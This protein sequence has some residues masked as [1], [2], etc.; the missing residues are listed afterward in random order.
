MPLPAVLPPAPRLHHLPIKPASTVPVFSLPAAH[1]SVQLMIEPAR[2]LGFAFASADVLFEIDARGTLLFVGGALK[3]YACDTEGSLVGQGAAVFFAPAEAAKLVTLAGAL[4][5]GDR[6]GPLRLKLAGGG[7]GHVC[8]CRLPQNG[9]RISCTLARTGARPSLVS[10]CDAQ[11]G[12]AGRESFLAAL[13][14]CGSDDELALVNIPSLPRV[15]ETLGPEK[16]EK[17][18]QHI[19]EAIRDCGLKVSGRLSPSTFGAIARAMKGVNPL[20]QA[21]RTALQ[22][23]GTG[24]LPIEETLVS[25]KSAV[26]SPEQRMLAVRYVVDK[27]VAGKGWRSGADLATAFDSLV[28]STQARAL[29]LTQ[30]VADG[31]FRLVYQPIVHLKTGS[32]SHYEALARF[33]AGGNT[34]EIIGFAEA[35]GIADAFDIAVL[36]K[37]IGLWERDGFEGA[38]VAFNVSGHTIVS[39]AA[40]GL[41]AGMLASRRALSGR[42]L[43]EVT[44]TAEITDF[45]AANGA[46]QMLRDMGFKVGIDDFGAGAASL[47]YLHAL[48][49]DFVKVDGAL[50]KKLGS[51]ERDDRMLGGIVK[52]CRELGVKTIAEYVED[53]TLLK[54]AR[55]IGFDLGQG[56]RFGAAAPM[57]PKSRSAATLSVAQLGKRRGVQESWG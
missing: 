37:L 34:G 9:G 21:I 29:A 11:T 6:A 22:Q 19:G 32:V 43:I 55:E 50:V 2:L 18:M 14:E 3:G 48:A 28:Q 7:E 27:F 52:L 23:G 30:T 57:I 13:A 15:C 10:E 40:F 1:H 42:L 44:E 17:L 41:L 12:L 31:Q 38:S 5:D 16:S 36:A 45:S 49:I 53:E 4:R 25:L 33:E 47:Q 54:R 20:G 24:A 35:L 26:L 51:S 39:P 8:V 56:H 46:I